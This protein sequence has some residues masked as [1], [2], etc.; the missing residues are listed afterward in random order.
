VYAIL[1]AGVLPAADLPAAAVAMATAGVAVF[2]VRGKDLA[3]G[4]LLDLA[5]AVRAALPPQALLVVDDRA[6]VAVAAGADGVH[7]GD[8]DLAPDQARRV[9]AP[10]ALVGWSTHSVADA[11]AAAHMG[12]DYAGFGPVFA[13]ATKATARPTLG[14]DGLRRA[15]AGNPLPL[16]AI[17]GIGLDDV[18][19]LAAAGASGVAMIAALLVPGEVAGRAARAVAAFRRGRDAG[20]GP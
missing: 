13:S 11:R 1:D 2:Q 5:R 20:G 12:C 9:L 7:L 3:A 4:A 19:A 16:V 15:A 17:G 8:E 18:E 10:G 6:D 14:V